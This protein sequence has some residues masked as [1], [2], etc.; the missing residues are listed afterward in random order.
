[1]DTEECEWGMKYKKSVSTR[2]ACRRY[3]KQRNEEK[4]S[5]SEKKKEEKDMGAD[6][7]VSI[8]WIMKRV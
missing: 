7:E 3:G 2:E 4:N 6:K 1:M 5:M 8:A